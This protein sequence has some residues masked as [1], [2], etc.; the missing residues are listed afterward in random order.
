MNLNDSVCAMQQKDISS[1][2]CVCWAQGEPKATECVDH[3][4]VA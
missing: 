2:Q 4:H 3:M 1:Q